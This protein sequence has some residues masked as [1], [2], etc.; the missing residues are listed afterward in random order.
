MQ[1]FTDSIDYAA[2]VTGIPPI[3]WGAPRLDSDGVVGRLAKRLYRGQA[4]RES[5]LQTD[6]LWGHLFLV[7]VAAE[8]H[9]DILVDLGREG[10][11]PA[12]ELLCLAGT[13]HQFH[14]FKGRAWASPPGNLY[15]SAH[16]APNRA[17]RHAGTCFTVLAAVSVLDAIDEVPGLENRAE[18]KWVNDVLIDGAKVGGVL[19]YTQS[20]G[21]RT[22]SVV[23]GVGLNVETTP[24]VQPTPFVPRVGSL[25]EVAKDPGLCNQRLVFERLS[26]ALG[27]NYAAVLS[28]DYGTLL[29]RYKDRSAVVGRDVALCTED[30]EADPEVVAEG[31][32]Q[33]LGDDLELFFEGYTE[34]FS[35]GRLMFVTGQR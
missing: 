33:T 14:G 10:G 9:Y 1:V 11:G 5:K 7:E 12:G 26:R 16:L 34:P 17:V 18:I 2:K 8:S 6:M 29:Q 13:G 19:A 21:V 3:A 24:S 23:V 27:E 31:R 20:E 4:F 25:R 35:R 28:G 15:L 32:V 22:E 30:S